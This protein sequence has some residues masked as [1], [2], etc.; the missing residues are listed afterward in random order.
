MN[1]V[2]EKLRSLNTLFS[3]VTDWLLIVIGVVLIV[4]AL[5]GIDVALA[6]YVIIGVG[7]LFV[8]FGFLYRYRR[9]R[10]HR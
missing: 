6:R 7:A 5:L 1:G 10:Q 2:Q 4:K 9:K 3:K 8:F